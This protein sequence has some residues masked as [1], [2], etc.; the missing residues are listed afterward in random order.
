LGMGFFIRKAFKAGPLRFNLSKGGIGV[1]AGATGARLGLNRN[2]AYVYGGRYGLYYREHLNRRKGESG[3]SESVSKPVTH[4]PT[5]ILVD[6]G[7]TYPSVYDLIEPH[8]YPELRE[9][10]KLHRNPVL[11]ILFI[12]SALIPFLFQ[13]QP[14]LWILPGLMFSIIAF[15]YLKDRKWR[16]RG[17]EMIESL[18]NDFE[19]TPSEMNLDRMNTFIDKAPDKYINRFLPDL[20]TVMLQIALEEGDNEHIFAFNKFE[21]QVPV[22]EEFIEQ[23]K[24]AILTRIMDS[25]LEEQLMSESQENEMRELIK[26]LHLDDQFIFEELQYLD[27]ASTI[28]K[29]M[30]SPLVETEASIPLINGEVCYAEFDNVRLLEERVLE[31]FKQNRVQY[32]KIG[33][34]VQLEGKLIL[35]NKRVVVAGS[36]TKEFNTDQILDVITNLDNNIIELVIDGWLKSVYITST[37]P[38]LISTRLEKI[39]ESQVTVL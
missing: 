16:K 29:E 27:L 37:M 24:K 30:Q 28:H 13:E 5:D 11:W 21:K 7:K 26:K 20:Y 3:D 8:P 23:T 9:L 2:G 34:E 4:G 6:T 36:G 17:R 39:R 12:L 22:S 25:L 18:S 35:T 31:R 10:N 1:S 14:L 38:V 33:Y 15:H 19:K 32:R